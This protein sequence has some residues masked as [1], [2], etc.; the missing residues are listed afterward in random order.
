MRVALLL[1]SSARSL[2]PPH[3]AAACACERVIAAPI[4][5]QPLVPLVRFA[6]AE[7]GRTQRYQTTVNPISGLAF[8]C[9]GGAERQVLAPPAAGG[10]A[11][12]AVIDLAYYY[13]LNPQTREFG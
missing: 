2:P 13:G 4:R 12:P 1:V 8:T 11:E 9:S 6:R 5:P 10:M 7:Q 3:A